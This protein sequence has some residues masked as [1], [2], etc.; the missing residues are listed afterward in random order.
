[1]S[2]VYLQEA[3]S[4][5]FDESLLK[6]KVLLRLEMG[7]FGEVITHRTQ[8]ASGRT[9]GY[10]KKDRHSLVNPPQKAKK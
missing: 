3:R 10:R 4:A 2:E 5:S 6:R 9:Y 7:W 1:M 8:E